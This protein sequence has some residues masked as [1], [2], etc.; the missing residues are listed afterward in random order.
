[1]IVAVAVLFVAPD[2]EPVTVNVRVP[3]R[4]LLVTATLKVPVPPGATG[5]VPVM[6]VVTPVVWPLALNVTLFVNP[7]TAVTSTA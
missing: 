2:A 5:F 7:L 4:A 1:M 6:D 3:L